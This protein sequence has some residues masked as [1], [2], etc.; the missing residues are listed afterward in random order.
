M[1]TELDTDTDT[2][3]EDDDRLDSDNIYEEVLNDKIDKNSQ[4]HIRLSTNSS[5]NFGEQ[6]KNNQ[7]QASLKE[8]VKKKQLSR[9]YLYKAQTPRIPTLGLETWLPSD[10]GELRKVP[11]A[12]EN[13]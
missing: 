8:Q 2:D 9:T 4:L 12:E 7:H 6:I 1:E 5:H 11:A 3:T 13:T 10:K